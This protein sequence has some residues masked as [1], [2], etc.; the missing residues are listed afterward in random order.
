[1]ND[2]NL[3]ISADYADA[4][5]V[6]R[7]AKN[8]LFLILL[9][10]LLAQLALF[11]IA[12]YTNLIAPASSAT[13]AVSAA[14]VTTMPAGAVTVPTTAGDK[15]RYF[16]ALATFIGTVLPVLMAFML[17]IIVHIMLVGR[18]IGVSR[19]T[20]AFCWCLLLML[21]LFPWQ[22]FF[23]A[24][25]NPADF[26]FSG[27]LYTWQDLV[28]AKFATSDLAVACLKWARFFVWP[29]VAVI[30]LLIVQVKSSRGIKQALGEE[31]IRSE[32]EPADGRA[33]RHREVNITV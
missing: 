23:G 1:M 19:V 13:P 7:R 18:L 21:I 25:T 30:L 24:S 32:S 26:R 16:N 28:Q 6:A 8:W 2:Q 20:S 9:L 17:L 3:A 15:L 12:R 11:F 5:L 27:V 29:L 31:P 4:M 14:A 33:A 10:V 22:A